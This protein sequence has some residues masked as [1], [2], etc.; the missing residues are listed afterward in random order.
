[1]HLLSQLRRLIAAL[2]IGF[3]I[4]ILTSKGRFTAESS[5]L[6]KK[7]REYRDKLAVLGISDWPIFPDIDGLGK[8]ITKYYKLLSPPRLDQRSP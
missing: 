7:K 3:K 1:M 5:Y 4:T 2:A 8:F 6:R